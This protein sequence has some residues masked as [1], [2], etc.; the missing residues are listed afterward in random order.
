MKY[1]GIKRHL[2]MSGGIL[3][4]A[5]ISYSAMLEKRKGGE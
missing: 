5:G 3:G 4:W 2:G 1:S